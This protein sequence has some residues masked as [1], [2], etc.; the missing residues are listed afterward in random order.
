SA[1][2]VAK[3]HTRL[4]LGVVDVLRKNF[5]T[6]NYCMPYLARPDHRISE[7]NSVQETGARCDDV[8][9]CRIVCAEFC[10]N[11]TA[12]RRQYLIGSH[13]GTKQQIDISRIETSPLD[14]LSRSANG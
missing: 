11:D 14:C 4:S 2:T 13:S 7:R 12:G 5:R 3:Q 9:R 8:H 6:D 10:L 1:C